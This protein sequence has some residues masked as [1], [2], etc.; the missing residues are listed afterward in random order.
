METFSTNCRLQEA[1]PMILKVYF[2][3]KLSTVPLLHRSMQPQ[4]EQHSTFFKQILQKTHLLQEK[5]TCK[6]KYS[7]PVLG[8]I[9]AFSTLLILL[10]SNPTNIK[11]KVEQ[12]NAECHADPERKQEMNQHYVFCLCSQTFSFNFSLSWP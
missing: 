1:H 6:I 3:N 7:Q 4:R 11:L 12:M 5:K 8:L 9:L 10:Y 2:L